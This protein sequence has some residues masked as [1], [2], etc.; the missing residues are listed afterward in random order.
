MAYIRRFAAGLALVLA[1]CA[2]LDPRL[3]RLAD[4][5]ALVAE[6]LDVARAPAP[7][8][9]AALA[10][11]QQAFMTDTTLMNRLRLATLLAVLSPPAR[12]EARAAELLEPIADIRAPGVGRFSAL[13]AAQIAERQRI[14][15]ELER[16]A[17][18]T[19]RGAREHERLDKE[20]DRR[21][22]ALR[23]QVEALRSIE[24][25]IQE[26][27]EKLRRSQR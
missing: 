1:G 12:D 18:E 15:R 27:E 2:A 3:A 20:R 11:A 21:E 16:L 4:V 5:D 17:R 24:R 23:Q 22:E 26:R 14:G 6:S 9:Q 8:Q 13:L 10:R 7:E 19:E 25:G